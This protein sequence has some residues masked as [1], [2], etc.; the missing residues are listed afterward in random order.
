MRHRRRLAEQ[1]TVLDDPKVERADRKGD[2][3]IAIINRFLR[4]VTAS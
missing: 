2:S 4:A 1:F 3:N